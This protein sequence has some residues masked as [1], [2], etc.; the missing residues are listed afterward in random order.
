MEKLPIAVQVYSVREEAAADFDGTMARLAGMGY[1]GV[2]LAGLYGKTPGEIRA[3]LDQHGLQAVSAHVPLDEFLK[4]MDGTVKAYGEI[5]CRFLAIP[6]LDSERWYGGSGYKELLDRISEIAEGCRQAGI[7][8]L[9]HNHSFE[10]EKTPEGGFQ[11]DAF[12]EEPGTA[13]LAAELDLCWVK[14]GGADPVEYLKK[15]SGRCPVVHVKDFVREDEV[16]LVAVG[17]GELEVEAVIRQA[18][19]SRAGWLVVEQDDHKYGNPM[20]N[21]KKSI[22]CIRSIMEK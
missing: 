14:V 4:D 17:D 7:Q 8:L 13:G 1:E 12:Y 15:Y 2:E 6:W 19:K 21:M 3:C 11:L 9:Y 20:E 22:D 10:F 18:A 16:T 5:G